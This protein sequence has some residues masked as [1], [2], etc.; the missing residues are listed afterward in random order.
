METVRKARLKCIISD[1][2]DLSERKN[3][4][5]AWASK[6]LVWIR[7]VLGASRPTSQHFT[8][9]CLVRYL[10]TL[11]LVLTAVDAVASIPIPGGRSLR[12]VKNGGEF[13]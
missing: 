6:F 2:D 8:L 12:P 7:L 10:L 3:L 4:V 9:I 11:C 1:R 5:T 13:W